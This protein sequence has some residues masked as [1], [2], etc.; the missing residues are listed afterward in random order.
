MMFRHH[1]LTT[2]LQLAAVAVCISTAALTAAE[3][4]EGGSATRTTMHHLHF[5]MHE[6]YAETVMQVANGTGAPLISRGGVRARFGDTAVMDDAL[7]EGPSPGSRQVG[8]AQGMYATASRQPGA[9][10]MLLTMNMVLTGFEGYQNGSMVAVVG[11]NDVTASVRELAV[12]GG[13]GSFRMATGYALL[14]TI[15]WK[16]VTAVLEL[17]VFVRA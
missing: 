16:G 1:R 15:S 14:K 6:T 13:T 17:D 7:T 10:A 4:D 9:P 11:W 8:R 12:V 5:Y 2:I 3:V